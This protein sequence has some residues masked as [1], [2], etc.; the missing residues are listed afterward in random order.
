MPKALVKLGESIRGFTLAQRTIAVIGLAIVVLGTVALVSFASQPKM[1]PLFTGLS[2][3]DASGIVEQLQADAV[4]YEITGAGGT[5]LVPQENVYEARLKA[6]TAGL[7]TAGA[8]GYSLLDQMGV[9]ASEFQQDVTYKRALEGELASTIM[10]LDSV[11][12]ASVKLAIPEQTVFVDSA[13]TPTASIFVQPK[14][15]TTLTADQVQAIVHLTSAA[16]D[17]LKPAD[18]SVVDSNGTLLSAAG[19]GVEGSAGK[20]ASEYEQRVGSMIQTMLDRVVGP[21]NATVAVAADVS[22]ESAE[23]TEES[24]SA[25]K[26]NPVLAEKS[27]KEDYQGSGNGSR[28]AGV[29]GPDNIAVPSDEA[30]DGTFTSSETDR[31]NAV[32]KVTENRLVPSGNLNRQSVSVALDAQAASGLDV[33]EL[34]AMISAAAGIDTGRKD[35]INVSVLPFSTESATAAQNALTEASD[36]AKAAR[37]AELLRTLVIAGSIVLVLVLLAVYLL[38]R[39]RN[40][41]SSELVDL[42]ELQDLRSLREPSAAVSVVADTPTTT[43]S[44]IPATVS[45]PHVQQL[46]AQTKREELSALAAQNPAKMAQHLRSLM[47]SKGDA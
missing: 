1:T 32:N 42:G 41:H 6:A 7:P 21:G 4:P 19:V 9:T 47:D 27:K 46:D 3:E 20:Q 34:T 33:Q 11:S 31:T 37:D 30:K 22:L 12:M 40:R 25:P 36:A 45:T 28:E 2:A 13:T 44:Q 35:T 39:R 15:N 17:G 16:V 14:P 24:F 5:I 23:R 38:L 29:L 43:I 26:D 10:A 18:I 8:G